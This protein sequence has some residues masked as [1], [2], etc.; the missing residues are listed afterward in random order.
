MSGDI[1]SSEEKI[2]I[3]LLYK[4]FRC[5]LLSRSECSLAISRSVSSLD[6]DRKN[7]VG[8]PYIQE[9]RANIYYS[10]VDIAKFISTKKI[11]TFSINDL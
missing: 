10:I 8:I 4:R 9:S 7:G 1:V 6:R 11:K 2:I 3:E 5:V